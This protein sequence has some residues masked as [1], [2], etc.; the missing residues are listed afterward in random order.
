MSTSREAQYFGRNQVWFGAGFQR[1]TSLNLSADRTLTSND[2]RLVRLNPSSAGFTVYLPE[3]PAPGEEFTFKEVA[4]STN[5]VVINGNGKDIEGSA[6]LTLNVARRCR[7]LRFSE[8]SG[9]WEIVGGV[10]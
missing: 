6:T 5:P 9:D 10:G 1:T 2:Q 3:G 8:V 4:G 7:T